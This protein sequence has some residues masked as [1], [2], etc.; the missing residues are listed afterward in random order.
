[1]ASP[2]SRV[3]VLRRGWP[4]AAAGTLALGAAVVLRHANPYAPGSVLP[5]CPLYALTGLYC[6]GCGSTRCLYSLLHADLAGA[7][8]M[9]PLLVVCLPLLLLMLLHNAG[10]RV[11][12]T[13]ALLRTL[14]NP[15]LWLVLLPGY[16]LLRNLP[17]PPFTALAP[18]S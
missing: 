11:P 2:S 15:M 12:G 4:L 17:W 5:G 8:A 1:M 18:L 7:W 9:N 14:A 3:R 10:V 13:Q 6:P 16:A